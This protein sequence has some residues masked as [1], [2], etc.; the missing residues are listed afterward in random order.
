MIIPPKK[1]IMPAIFL[2]LATAQALWPMSAACA[3]ESPEYLIKAGF[4]FNIA[5]FVEWRDGQGPSRDLI[6]GIL[7]DDPF[8]G[9]IRAIEGQTVNGRR[10]VVHRVTH[11][12]AAKKCH[13]LFICPSERE[14]MEDILRSLQ[15]SPVL[16]IGDTPGFARMGGIINLIKLGDSIRFETNVEAAGRA[17]LSISSEVLKLAIIVK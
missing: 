12:E 11:L 13:I 14:H 2:F 16:T 4:I 15:G 10:L 3:P 7:G 1:R 9:N 17:G 6:L 8:G 5:R